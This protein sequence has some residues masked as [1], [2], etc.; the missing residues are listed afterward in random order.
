VASENHVTF[1][2]I[3]VRYQPTEIGA[4]AGRLHVDT[5][6]AIAPASLD[7]GLVGIGSGDG[8]ATDPDFVN[9]GE[10]AVGQSAVKSVRVFN[11]R[12]DQARVNNSCLDTNRDDTCDVDCTAVSETAV[13]S[14]GVEKSDGSHEGK[15]FVLEPA[16]AQ[17]GGADERTVKIRWAPDVAGALRAQLLLDTAIAGGRVWKV[18]VN[19]GVAGTFTP[20][21]EPV[22]IA[23]SGDPLAGQASFTVSNTG[24]APLTIRQVNFAGAGS[25]TGEFTLTRSGDAG[26]S[27]NGTTPWTGTVTIEQGGSSSF[28]LSYQNS[29]VINCDSFDIHWFHD[30]DGQDPFILGVEVD[31]DNC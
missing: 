10:V 23:A 7:I 16:D 27:V 3:S 30:G 13:V 22:V 24:Q 8:I 19:G 28:S 9:F 15:G 12:L 26:F 20:S 18:L 4:D 2:E 11:L 5:D 31:G 21:V 1:V 17:A 14:C 6:A 29:G 25:I